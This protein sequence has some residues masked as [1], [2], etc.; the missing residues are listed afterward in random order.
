MQG[1]RSV[2][3]LNL[4]V[5]FF[6]LSASVSAPKIHGQPLK[7]H[8]VC[9]GVTLEIYSLFRGGSKTECEEES[10]NCQAGPYTKQIT[11]DLT[12][13]CIQY[14]LSAINRERQ[15]E[16]ERERWYLGHWINK[17]SWY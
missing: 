16:R 5:L 6:R 8:V 13:G 2:L 14:L 15:R 10:S 11:E 3:S 9:V 17:L 4:K 1:L 12:T 7:N